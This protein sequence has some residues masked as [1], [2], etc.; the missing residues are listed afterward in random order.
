ML[1][2]CSIALAAPPP[3]GKTDTYYQLLPP[4]LRTTRSTTM[5]HQ[6]N[7]PISIS[8]TYWWATGRRSW[9]R[10]CATS[11][12]R[13]T[14]RSASSL[15]SRSSSSPSTASARSR[16]R[17]STGRQFNSIKITWEFF[18]QFSGQFYSLQVLPL[19]EF[20]HASF[21]IC[22][23]IDFLGQFFIL[24]NCHPEHGAPA[25]RSSP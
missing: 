20:T 3:R 10:Y 25:A 17:L 15:S 2:S 19:K 21:S 9:D 5:H 6:H 22:L 12:C 7:F 23:C 14:T 24:L 16:W 1:L 18:E 11:G 13:W 8:D 4:S